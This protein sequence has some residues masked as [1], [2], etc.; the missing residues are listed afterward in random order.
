MHAKGTPCRADAL[1]GVQ[2]RQIFPAW[3][4]VPRMRS[5]VRTP[6]VP[7]R[8][9]GCWPPRVPMPAYGMHGQTEGSYR[10]AVQAPLC[11][12]DL[13]TTLVVTS[14]EAPGEV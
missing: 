1:H 10:T 3:R 9:C 7:G 13:L 6:P 4:A 5:D 14:G 11:Y 8:P 2:I 12:V